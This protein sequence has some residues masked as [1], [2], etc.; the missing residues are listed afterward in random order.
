MQRN[1]RVAHMIQPVSAEAFA[2]APNILHVTNLHCSPQLVQLTQPQHLL[3]RQATQTQLLWTQIVQI[4]SK[5]C[6]KNSLLTTV[7]MWL[8]V[9]GALDY[10]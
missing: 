2:L 7:N 8:I 4:L 10:D 6:Q 5:C 9:T 1:T 3:G